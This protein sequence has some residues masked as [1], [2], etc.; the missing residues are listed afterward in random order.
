[1]IPDLKRL[2]AW[3]VDDS[4]LAARGDGCSCGERTA[5]TDNWPRPVLARLASRW[6]YPGNWEGVQG[7]SWLRHE[8]GREKGKEGVEGTTWSKAEG[9]SEK[10]GALTGADGNGLWWPWTLSWG[11]W[12]EENPITLFCHCLFCYFLLLLFTTLN[13]RIHLSTYLWSI[14]F[15]SQCECKQHESKTMLILFSVVTPVPSRVP[16]T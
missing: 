12:T 16:G 6:K 7:V 10:V 8:S 11:Q 1:M 14:P 15:S 13:N 2:T 4:Q 9:D 5:Q 3:W